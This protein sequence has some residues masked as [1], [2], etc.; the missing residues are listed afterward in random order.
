MA[1]TA[2][3]PH[4][5]RAIADEFL[6]PSVLAQHA[7]RACGDDDGVEA[8]V[9]VRLTAS[10]EQA[11]ATDDASAL[12][13]LLDDITDTHA[14]AA[15]AR[16]PSDLDAIRSAR[17][18]RP[19][20]PTVPRSQREIADRIHAGWLGRAVGCTLG[21]PVEGWT[22]DQIVGYLTAIGETDIVDYLPHGDDV[23]VDVDRR[24]GWR[25]GSCRG[26]VTMAERDDD[27]D[28][29]VV[30]LEVLAEHG[31]EFRTTDVA[32]AWLDRLPYRATCTAE[33]VAYRNL[34][35]G[36]APPA[37][38]TVRNP[39]RQWVGAQIRADVFGYVCPG[40]PQRAAELA[41][42]DARLSH[43]RDGIF[44]AMWVAAAISAAFTTDD[45]L[46]VVTIATSEIPHTSRFSEMVATVLELHL[47]YPDWRD[48]RTAIDRMYG[49]LHPVHVIN[50]AA[51][52]VL[53]LVYGR[54]DF[55]TTVGIAVASGWDTDSNGATA[56]SIAGVM[57]GTKHVPGHWTDP[58][59]DT[60]DTSIVGHGQRQISQ[61]ASTTAAVAR[62]LEE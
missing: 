23:P 51:L 30:N 8:D 40:R 39:Y 15:D 47:R 27:L 45:P 50:N 10:V 21:R 43:R 25:K 24:I 29:T 46:D 20:E 56:G 11:L 54:G 9:L 36:L 2:G 35:L 52:V 28:Y 22:H 16:E 14:A 48:A 57:L 58:L 33:R 32:L 4:S 6:D 59:A 42:R 3:K 18:G 31:H 7:L 26:H 5:D 19:C 17:P 38:A 41:W 1:Q 44:G 62:R 13:A 53:S 37:T 55:T 34:V 61:L 49:H 12:E 60:L